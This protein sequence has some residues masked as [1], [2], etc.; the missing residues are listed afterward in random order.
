LV[1]GIDFGATYSSREYAWGKI[2][3]E[4]ACSYQ[5]NFAVQNIE[6]T[7][8]NLP[9]L[10]SVR[11]Q[12]TGVYPE[13][14]SYGLPDFKMVT[15]LFYS[16]ALF[17]VGRFRAGLTLSYIDSEHDYLDN[18]KGTNPS[19]L[20]EPNGTVH[21]VGSWTALDLQVSYSFGRIDDLGRMPLPGYSADGKRQLGESAIL[22]RPDGRGSQWKNWFG[23]VT[24]TF[25]I[26]NLED[27]Q[28]PFSDNMFGY[29]ET[30]ANPIGRYFYLELEKKF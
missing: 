18:F 3:L 25:G 23:G 24:L 9:G 28:P 2:E 22:P 16:K 30:T 21:R 17:G 11:I 10:G 4:V 19:A 15:S 5:Y 12:P 13:D 14:D 8:A 26:N 6:S 1:D 27:S 7:S 20:L 29:D